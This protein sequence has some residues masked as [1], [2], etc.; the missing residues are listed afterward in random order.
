MKPKKTIVS[1]K[2]LANLI[3]I[4]SKEEARRL[5]KKGGEGGKGS[6]K[7][8]LSARL[9]VLR[10]KA[11]KGWTT[12]VENKF[13]QM[14]ENPDVFDLDVLTVLQSARS[15]AVD[16]QDH[17]RVARG[18]IEARKVRHGSADRASD[19]V[20]VFGSVDARV[21]NVQVLNKGILGVLRGFPDAERAVL[22]FLEKGDE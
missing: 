11:G 8:S 13:L 22:E 9:R 19:V 14:L 2:S 12:E 21:L 1:K 3:P 5:G 4:K 16:S 6:L 17:A 7:K 20:N 10:Q 15:K 18:L